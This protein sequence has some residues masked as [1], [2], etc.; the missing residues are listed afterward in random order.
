MILSSSSSHSSFWI[1]TFQKARCHCNTQPHHE[2]KLA[3]IQ[4]LLSGFHKCVFPSPIATSNFQSFPFMNNVPQI[5]NFKLLSLA[6]EALPFPYFIS[7][8]PVSWY[9]KLITFPF[10]CCLPITF[11]HTLGEHFHTLCEHKRLLAPNKCFNAPRWS[12]F[13]TNVTLYHHYLLDSFPDTWHK[14]VSRSNT[15]SL[16]EGTG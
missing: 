8:K 16:T 12:C 6:L 5:K 7:F 3:S 2:Y 4:N 13:W 14:N 9:L 1:F 11:L 15:Y 10:E